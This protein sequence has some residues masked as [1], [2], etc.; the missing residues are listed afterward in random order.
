M[1]TQKKVN[2]GLESMSF[3]HS[4]PTTLESL[5]LIENYMR[6]YDWDGGINLNVDKSKF[7]KIRIPDGK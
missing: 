5:P 3:D 7:Y 2:E 6:A 4:F 1:L